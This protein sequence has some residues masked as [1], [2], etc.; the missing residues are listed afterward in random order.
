MEESRKLPAGAI[1][2]VVKLRPT[3]IRAECEVARPSRNHE[4]SSSLTLFYINFY[5]KTTHVI[6]RLWC[7][8]ATGADV[9]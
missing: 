4:R 7:Y 5:Q 8:I 9:P 2:S 1:P 6:Y 3:I